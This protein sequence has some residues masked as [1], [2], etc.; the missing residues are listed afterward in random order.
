MC[1][2]KGG[3]ICE[4]LANLGYKR[5]ELAAAD[6]DITDKEY[7][8]TILRGISNKLVTFA[9]QLLSSALIVYN[10]ASINIDTLFNQINEEADQLK[11]R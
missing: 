6:V 1:C 7:E 2:T 4:F 9:L 5:E 11:T 8:H 10:T 3:D